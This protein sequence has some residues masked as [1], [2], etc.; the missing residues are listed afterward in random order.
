MDVTVYF[1]GFQDIEYHS[2]YADLQPSNIQCRHIVADSYQT[3]ISE[4][5]FL[6]TKLTLTALFSQ[7]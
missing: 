6:N 2:S 3:S 7:Q 1:W 4:P 5:C